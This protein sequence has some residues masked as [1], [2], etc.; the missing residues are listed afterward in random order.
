MKTIQQVLREMDEES[1]E[2]AFFEEH[3]IN[4]FDVEGYDEELTIGAYL[5][6]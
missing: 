6:T 2:R 5:V 1:I 4:I 3:P